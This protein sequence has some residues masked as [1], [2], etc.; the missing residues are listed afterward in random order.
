MRHESCGRWFRAIIIQ[1]IGYR[2]RA[3][4]R[5]EGKEWTLR[6]ATFIARGSDLI[7]IEAMF[8]AFRSKEMHHWTSSTLKLA[9]C[10]VMLQEQ[11]VNI[12]SSVC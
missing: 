7:V 1:V 4:H 12:V 2:G 11:R 10:R 9:W 8:D 3:I 5:I 6:K